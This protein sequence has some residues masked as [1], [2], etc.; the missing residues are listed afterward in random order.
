MQDYTVHNSCKGSREQDIILCRGKYA[1]AHNTYSIWIGSRIPFA[2]SD[3]YV[4]LH[5][6]YIGREQDFVL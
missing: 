6:N 4:G 1:G 2:V 5:T 3:K